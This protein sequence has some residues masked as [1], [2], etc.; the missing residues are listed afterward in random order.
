LPAPGDDRRQKVLEAEGHR[1]HHG[2]ERDGLLREADQG[3]EENPN[4][5]QGEQVMGTDLQKIT[6]HPEKP[7]NRTNCW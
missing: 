2:R 1:G 3:I 7:H 5:S 6:V 4:I